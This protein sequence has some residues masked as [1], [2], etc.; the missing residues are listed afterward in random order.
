M[1]EE[2]FVQEEHKIELELVGSFIIAISRQGGQGEIRETLRQGAPCLGASR[3]GGSLVQT[4]FVSQS[5][6][7]LNA[8][9]CSCAET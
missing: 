4:T 2:Y 8:H 9:R 3:E 5:T 6:G 1:T 7:L